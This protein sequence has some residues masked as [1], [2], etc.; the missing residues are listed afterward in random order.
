MLIGLLFEHLRNQKRNYK[1][2]FIRLY[3]NRGS[4]AGFGCPTHS[5]EEEAIKVEERERES[6][7]QLV[8]I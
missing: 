6:V 3:Y 4:H 2:R 7:H 1:H 5:Q 8:A